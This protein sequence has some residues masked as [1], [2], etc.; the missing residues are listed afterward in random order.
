[1]T[2]AK[3]STK[4]VKYF[5]KGKEEITDKFAPAISDEFIDK[6]PEGDYSGQTIEV[7]SDTHLEQDAG[8]GESFILRTYEFRTSP[9]F[10]QG[11]FPSFQEIF[12]SHIKGIAGMLWGDGLT[13]ATDLEPRIV[14]SKDKSK[15]LIMVWARPSIGQTIIEKPYTL[16]EIA[17]LH[18]RRKN[19]NSL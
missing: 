5:I 15:Y 6:Q 14:L 16:G 12:D 3:K 8:T 2:K 18:E 13:P 19:T 17:Q 9:E 1:M 11:K 10:L 4:Q 7:H